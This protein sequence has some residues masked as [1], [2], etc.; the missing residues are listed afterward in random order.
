VNKLIAFLLEHAQIDFAGELTVETVREFLREDPSSGARALMNKL[1]DDDDLDE[2]ILTLSD[3]LK[4]F[5]RTGVNEKVVDEQI[6]IYA[7][8]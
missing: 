6:R 2:M 4:E 7:E 1:G 3:C 8:A 5:I